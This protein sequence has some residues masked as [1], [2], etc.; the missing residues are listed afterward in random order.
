LQAVVAQVDDPADPDAARD[1]GGGP[2]GEDGH[3]EA[4]GV[5]RR[6]PGQPADGS[7]GERDDRRRTRI[8]RALG[9]GAVEV[10]DDEQAT[11]SRAEPGDRSDRGLGRT[12]LDRRGLGRTDRGLG[13][14]GLGRSGL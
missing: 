3:G 12:G 6:E 13:R 14:R 10:G 11:R 4:V 5:G 2:A 1:V 8:A 9:E 7:T